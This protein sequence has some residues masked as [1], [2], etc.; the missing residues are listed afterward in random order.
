MDLAILAGGPWTSPDFSLSLSP[1][2]E[3]S[4]TRWSLTISQLRTVGLDQEQTSLKTLHS[5]YQLQCL[6]GT[7]WTLGKE[8]G[9][10]RSKTFWKGAPGAENTSHRE[11][12][13]F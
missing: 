8:S 5:I 10:G 9:K 3:D 7:L 1:Q 11:S 4:W 12:A 13:T 2:G 6:S